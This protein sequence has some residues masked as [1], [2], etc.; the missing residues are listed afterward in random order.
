MFTYEIFKFRC[1]MSEIA[2]SKITSR[3]RSVFLTDIDQNRF[4]G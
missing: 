3:R 1:F 2:K 4:S